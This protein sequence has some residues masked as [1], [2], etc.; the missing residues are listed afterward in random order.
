M[1]LVMVIKLSVF[2]LYLCYSQRKLMQP[3]KKGCKVNFVRSF[4][5]GNSQIVFILL[6]EI[7]TI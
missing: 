7:V 5:S 2:N 4:D 3:L 1:S 6:I